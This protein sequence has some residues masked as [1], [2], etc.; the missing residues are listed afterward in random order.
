MVN[1]GISGYS[2]EYLYGVKDDYFKNMT[3]EESI[4]EKIKL[5]KQLIRELIDSLHN[6]TGILTTDKSKDIEHRISK[7][8]EAIEYNK[9]LLE[10]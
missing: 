7:I 1:K 2:S 6:F 10:I 8:L 3:Y 5:G 9:S 4:K